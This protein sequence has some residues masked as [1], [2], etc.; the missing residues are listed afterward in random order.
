M[1][2]SDLEQLAQ[3]ATPG[4]W[5]EFESYVVNENDNVI[6]DCAHNCPWSSAQTQTNAAYIAAAS[7]DVVLKLIAVAKL[8]EAVS[9]WGFGKA[10]EWGCGN[11]RRC[12][13]CA[14]E[15]A[16]DALQRGK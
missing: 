15:N 7:P 9:Y 6:A 13:G 3:A 2:L 11:G 8:A 14:L 4:P 16:L 5:S 10:H 12:D 1:T